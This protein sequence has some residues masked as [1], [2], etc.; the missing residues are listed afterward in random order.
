MVQAS[1]LK[2]IVIIA[3]PTASGKTA[4]SL[5][6]AKKLDGEIIGC[7]SMQI[8]KGLDIGTG[9]ITEEEKGQIPHFMIDIIPPNS[10]FSVNDYVKSCDLAIG[11][12]TSRGKLPIIVGGTG[13]YVWGIL[14]GLD[15]AEAAKSE[16]IRKKYNKLA[17][18]KGKDHV[19]ELLKK[20]DP[21]A[22][23]KISANDLKRVIRAL[24]IYELTGKTKTEA[25]TGGTKRYDYKLIIISPPRQTLYD[26]INSRVD[27]MIQCGMV[28][29]VESLYKY[30]DCQSMQA[31]G[32][33]ELV[34]YIDG[35]YSLED[36]VETIKIN[37]RHY[38]KRQLTYFRNMKAEKCIYEDYT[39]DRDNEILKNIELFIKG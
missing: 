20:I 31:I 21:K 9:K 12:I 24:E 33:K 4:L 32:Y 34:A 35:K 27:K 38:A 1:S 28:K 16:E 30:R 7:D 26:N 36:A 6:C 22:C 8:Y 11:D 37:T 23:E 14:N 17:E 10:E 2:K 39:E 18:E 25:A 29:E 19:F 13:L 3:G 5:K 15:Y